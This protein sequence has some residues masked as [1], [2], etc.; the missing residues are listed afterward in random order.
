M[1]AGQEGQCT[2]LNENDIYGAKLVK[3][4]DLSTKTEVI[5]WLKCRRCCNLSNLILKKLKNK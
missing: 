1:A 4:I 2:A 5:R 3:E